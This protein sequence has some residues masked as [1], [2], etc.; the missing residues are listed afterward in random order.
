M[1]YGSAPLCDHNSGAGKT[2]V[3][4]LSIG[5]ALPWLSEEGFDLPEQYIISCVAN[6]MILKQRLSLL[7]RAWNVMPV[8]RERQR[9][10]QQD[11]HVPE[12]TPRCGQVAGWGQSRSSTNF[13]RWMRC[14]EL[15]HG[16]ASRAAERGRI[17]VE[18]S[19]YS[20]HSSSWP[21]L[22]KNLQPQ[23]NTSHTSFIFV[24]LEILFGMRAPTLK[25]RFLSWFPTLKIFK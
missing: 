15:L 24:Y 8:W 9:A 20:W 12:A 17:K 2:N 19:T 21:P 7:V 25:L 6:V 13:C 22:F 18:G 11:V 1:D 3:H 16:A 14:K 10:L 5:H 23:E 4:G